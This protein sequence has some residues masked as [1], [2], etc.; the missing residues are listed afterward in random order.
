MTPMSLLTL[1]PEALRHASEHRSPRGERR[2]RFYALVLAGLLLGAP[3]GALLL[4]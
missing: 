2:E 1:P 3:L 4:H